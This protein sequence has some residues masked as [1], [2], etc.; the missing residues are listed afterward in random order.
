MNHQ[1]LSIDAAIDQAHAE[2]QRAEA[3]ARAIDQRIGRIDGLAAYSRGARRHGRLRNPWAADQ[4]N[5]TAQG[6]IS[7]ADPQLAQWLASQAGMSLAGPDYAAEERQATATE[8][9]HR[10]AHSLQALQQQAAIH[11]QQ[12][13]QKRTYGYRIPGSR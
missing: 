10:M 11:R 4:S 1:Q 8:Q 7:R 12:L 2:A 6:L 9:A 5:L 13:E 3:D